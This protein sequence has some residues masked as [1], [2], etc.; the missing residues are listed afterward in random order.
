MSKVEEAI[1]GLEHAIM[2]IPVDE[3]ERESMRARIAKARAEHAELVARCARYE[4]ALREIEIAGTLPEHID[5]DWFQSKAH[6][7]LSAAK[8]ASEVQGG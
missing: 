7:T 4:K 1:N 8:A 3:S 5:L 2:W 6:V